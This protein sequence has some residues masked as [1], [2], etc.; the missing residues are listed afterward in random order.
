[1]SVRSWHGGKVALVWFITVLVPVGMTANA[2][3]DPSS[4]LL[5]AVFTAALA[6]ILFGPAVLVTWRWLSGRE[7]RSGSGGETLGRSPE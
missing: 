4:D 6:L 3:I 1:M 5:S 2:L 7:R